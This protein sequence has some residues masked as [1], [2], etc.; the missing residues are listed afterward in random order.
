MGVVPSE[1]AI[2]AGETWRL[3]WVPAPP[4]GKSGDHLGKGT[5]SSIEFQDRRV[6]QV[7]DD[8]RHLDWRAFARTGELTIKLYREELLP[9]LDLLIDTSSSME[10]TESKGQLAAD[11][12]AFLAIS[13]RRQGFAVRLIELGDAP[14]QLDQ[15]AL[16][17]EGVSFSGRLPLAA[18]LEGASGLLRPGTLRILISDFLCPH[19]AASVVRALA[20]R[21]GGLAVFQVLAEEDAQP[22]VGTALRMEDSETGV[23]REIVLD[24][25]TVEDYL[26]RLRRLTDSLEIECRRAAARFHR[27]V[28]GRSLD[29]ICRDELARAALIVPG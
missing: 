15:D 4:R 22:Q 27:L 7:G 18:T 28:S 17:R 23:Q 21:A 20:S 5:G 10:V 3:A 16:R 1:A 24:P 8:V 25:Q 2:R 19:D 12:L 29:E 13:A 9:R 11:L 14:R 6:Y 26:S